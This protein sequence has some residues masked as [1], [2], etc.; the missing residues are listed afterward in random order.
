MQFVQVSYLF[1]R[2]LANLDAG[3]SLCRADTDG[4]QW[5]PE[6]NAFE[7]NPKEAI[8][9]SAHAVSVMQWVANFFMSEARKNDHHFES[10][11]AETEALIY[12][13]RTTFT[14]AGFTEEYIWPQPD[15]KW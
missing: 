9:H 13:Y 10:V 4:T 2:R 1:C 14:N 8:P 12:N 15:G 6:K 11:E 5:H 7:W 3:S